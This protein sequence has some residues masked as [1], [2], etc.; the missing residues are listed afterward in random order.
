MLEPK[1]DDFLH[2]H[3]WP[4]D[5]PS[6]LLVIS[7]GLGEHGARYEHVA[8]RFNQ[9]GFL[10]A[11]IDHRGHGRSSGK[12][13]HINQFRDYSDDLHKLVCEIKSA[14]PDVPCYMLGHSMGGLIATAYG[15]RYP[16]F[17]DKLAVTAPGYAVIGM[18]N[19]LSLALA[20]LLAS[21]Y[22]GLSLSNGLDPA[23]ISRDIAVVQAYQQDTLVH[24]RVTAS[25]ARGFAAEQRFVRAEIHR[26]QVPILMLLAGADSL[27]DHRIAESLFKEIVAEEKKCCLFTEAFHEILNEEEKEQALEELIAWFQPPG[28]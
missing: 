3:H 11:A 20:P 17:I 8:E 22:P 4:I 21:V 26:L 15:L 1:G 13:G 27:T 5:Q 2:Y 16:Q 10:V 19:K 6:A 7:H 25:W 24:D 18:G 23:A 28:N 12:R 14:H 9:R